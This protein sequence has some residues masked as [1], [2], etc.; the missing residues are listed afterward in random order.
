MLPCSGV[1]AAGHS[2]RS[3]A[4][5]MKD[6]SL[7]RILVI[8]LSVV[9]FVAVLV[10]NALAGAGRGKFV[11]LSRLGATF[12]YMYAKSFTLKVVASL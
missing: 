12:F 9:V 8:L 3:R 6:N 10:V 11:C 1:E 5:N 7:P 4:A 2:A